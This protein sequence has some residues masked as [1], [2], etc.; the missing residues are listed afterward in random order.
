MQPSPKKSSS[1]GNFEQDDQDDQNQETSKPEEPGNIPQ[2]Y[3]LLL[4]LDETLVRSSKQK[5]TIP[6]YG[7]ARVITF[8]DNGEQT[9][10]YVI[11]RP[12]LKEFITELSKKYKIYIY[13]SG[14]QEYAEAVVKSSDYSRLIS[15]I[16]SRKD[17]KITSENSCEKD[18]FA[19]GFDE[20]KLVFI[21]DWKSHTTHA[22]NNSITIKYFSGRQSDRELLKLKDFLLE[23]VQEGDVRCVADRYNEYR[24]KGL[25][26]EVE[27]PDFKKLIR[28]QL[29]S[30]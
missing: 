30:V 1:H 10:M 23:L 21:D 24:P 19:F 20:K 22:P 9:Q 27:E 13:T 7:E 18:I 26:S 28:S 4:D 25:D 8:M 17:C 15:G 11:D 6:G 29:I 12:Y 2:D 14:I 5:P 3:V 16:Y